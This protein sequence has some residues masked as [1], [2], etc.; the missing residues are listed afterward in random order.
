M[1]VR[2]LVGLRFRQTPTVRI[3][4]FRITEGFAL[5]KALSRQ[6]RAEPIPLVEFYVSPCG[7]PITLVPV[8]QSMKIAFVPSYVPKLRPF[9]VQT[10]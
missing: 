8:Q 2:E 6:P 4:R 10:A 9:W 1:Q 7:A 5:A 3:W